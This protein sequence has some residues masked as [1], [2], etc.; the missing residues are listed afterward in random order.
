MN[1]YPCSDV[2]DGDEMLPSYVG[3][4]VNPYNG[5]VM[6]PIRIS[7]SMIFDDCSSDIFLSFKRGGN[8]TTK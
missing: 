5:P 7:C 1:H 3:I 4:I 6:E 8:L 2:Y